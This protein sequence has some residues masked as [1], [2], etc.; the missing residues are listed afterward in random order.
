VIALCLNNEKE[1][2]AEEYFK[3]VRTPRCRIAFAG[4]ASKMLPPA[5]LVG[6]NLLLFT[7]Q[8]QLIH[9]FNSILTICL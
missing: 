9:L 2:V 4:V 3:E 5:N 7:V 1:V 6:L 8:P